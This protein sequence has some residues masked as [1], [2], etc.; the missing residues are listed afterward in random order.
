MPINIPLPQ[1]ADR[2][3]YALL[4]EIL[5]RAVDGSIALPDGKGIILASPN[6]T[7]YRLGVDNDGALTTTPV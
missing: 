3:L 6:K 2:G 1:L 5:R 7:K 4:A